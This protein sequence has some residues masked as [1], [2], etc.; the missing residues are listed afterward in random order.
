MEICG[1]EVCETNGLVGVGGGRG[2][3]IEEVG[4]LGA[5]WGGGSS[6]GLKARKLELGKSWIWDRPFGGKGGS[7]R[8]SRSCREE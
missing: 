5:V 1:F 8:Q 7:G 2:L 4:K 3:G 6:V